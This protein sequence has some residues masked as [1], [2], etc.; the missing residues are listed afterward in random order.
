MKKLIA[1]LIFSIT[2]SNVTNDVSLLLFD[3]VS[4]YIFGE[5]VIYIN[6]EGY[7][8]VG[9]LSGNDSISGSGSFV[10]LSVFKLWR[11]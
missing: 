11:C 2:F 8:E 9:S 4:V 7:L 1:L 6:N 10:N 3:G 5:L